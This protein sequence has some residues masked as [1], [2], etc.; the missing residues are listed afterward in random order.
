MNNE[1]NKNVIFIYDDPQYF[2]P[3]F[4]QKGILAYPLFKELSLAFRII[5]RLFFI[6]RL[7]KNVWYG[8]WKYKLLNATTIIVFS[9]EYI[10]ALTYIKSINPQLRVVFWYW[11]PVFR[12]L[13]PNDI[14]GD[15]CEKWS[16]DKNDC[17]LFNMK[18][19]TTFYLDNIT[20]PQNSILYDVIFLGLDK[21]RRSFIND[22]E[23]KMVKNGAK[24]YFYIV[25]DNANKRNYKG[26]FPL[27]SYYEYLTIISKSIAILDFI[28]EGQNGLTLRPMES[29]FF[30]KKLITNDVSIKQYNFYN[31]NNIFIIGID[32]IEHLKH[33]LSLPYQP[34][35]KEIL[36][37]YDV[38]NWLKRFIE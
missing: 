24:P 25:D 29:L 30:Q 7:P 23:D 19:N 26:S 20:L 3:F 35:S 21:G 1:E 31:P 27:I 17:E 2:I 33:F 37:Y 38:T 4:K 32:R 22:I 28:Q 36:E 11:N 13:N 5:R 34:V 12:S 6:L 18:S 8:E 14:P 16:F 10:E 9:I 15:L